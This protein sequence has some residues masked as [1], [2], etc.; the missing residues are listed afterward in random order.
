MSRADRRRHARTADKTA[1]F[2]DN[3]RWAAKYTFAI[4]FLPLVIALPVL[5]VQV[6][7]RQVDLKE[8]EVEVPL[9]IL[10]LALCAAATAA[11][12]AWARPRPWAR[13]W[14]GTMLIGS[15]MS[16]PVMLCVIALQ[17]RS[18]WDASVIGASLLLAFFVLGPILGLAAWHGEVRPNSPGARRRRSESR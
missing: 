4:A 7:P 18:E 12:L 2:G 8:A 3:F 15:L 16:I 10:A 13:R 17:P 14:W 9:L 6:G 1:S 11:I 5:L